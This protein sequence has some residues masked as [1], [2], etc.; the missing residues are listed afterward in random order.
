VGLK[1]VL[2]RQR[3][4]FRANEPGRSNYQQLIQEKMGVPEV[5]LFKLEPTLPIPIDTMSD[6]RGIV[7][8]EN[9]WKI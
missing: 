9:H 6:T 7:W 1:S 5:R 3:G 4:D 2:R 8:S